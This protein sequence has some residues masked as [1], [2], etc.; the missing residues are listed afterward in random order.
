MSADECCTG[1]IHLGAISPNL[2]RCM[3]HFSAAN[4]WH[5]FANRLLVLLTSLHCQSLRESLLSGK[6]RVT[7]CSRWYAHT[8][9]DLP[10]QLR[11]AVPVVSPTLSCWSFRALVRG[12]T[13]D[14]KLPQS[15]S[16]TS[17]CHTAEITP[18]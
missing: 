15:Y 10:E 13:M 17:A 14:G 1:M 3:Q 7:A 9:L 4:T 8:L 18:R 12:R 11:W 5:H 6:L 2:L 16:T